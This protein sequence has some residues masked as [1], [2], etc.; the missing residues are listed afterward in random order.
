ME[1]VETPEVLLCFTCTDRNFRYG[2]LPTYKHNRSPQDKPALLKQL[3]EYLQ[4]VYPY[5]EKSH[6]E[7]DDVMGILATLHPDKYLI[8]SIDKDLKQIPGLHYNWNEAEFREVSEMEGDWWFYRQV[9]TGDTTDGYKGCPGVGPKKAAKIL[10]LAEE[11]LAG[12]AIWW[13][14]VK[15]AYEAKG[16]TEEDALVQARVARILRAE[17]YDMKKQEVKLWTPIW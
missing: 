13:K 17:D 12:N 15:E 16:L 4:G 9:L 1:L 14:K 10:S 7:G 5:K 3:R 8:A 2:I 11:E 6:L